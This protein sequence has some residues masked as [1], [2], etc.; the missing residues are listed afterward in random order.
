MYVFDSNILIDIFNY[1]YKE[2]FPTFWEHFEQAIEDKQLVS[3]REVFNEISSSN[4]EL[5]EWAK[6]NKDFFLKPNEDEYIFLNEIFKIHHFQASIRQQQILRGM[7]VADPFLIIKAKYLNATVV[8]KEK[9]KENGV[10]IPNICTH[11]NVKYLN[12][13]GFLEEVKWKS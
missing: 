10:N 8:T 6:S 11:F 5:S 3:V 13:K 12:L 7:P 1:Y 9:F 2:N 4:D